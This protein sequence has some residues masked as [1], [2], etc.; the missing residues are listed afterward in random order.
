MAESMLDVRVLHRADAEAAVA[1]G[2]DRLTVV[3]LGEHR[4]QAPEPAVV[5][6]VARVS[7]LPVRV[8]L[9]LAADADSGDTTT[10]AGLVRMVGLAGDYV[11]A[12]ADGVVAGFLTDQ[13]EVD[14]E[15]GTALGEQLPCPWTFSRAIDRTLDHARSWRRVLGLPGVDSVLSAGSAVDAEH[16]HQQLIELAR[17]RTVAARLIAAGEVRPEHVPWLLRA[18]VRRVHIAGA[19][20][21]GGSWTKAHVDAGLVRS[22]RLLLDD[23]LAARRPRG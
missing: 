4:A 12:G 10:G 6:E 2:A 18:G 7:E 16:G 23:E 22:W 9:R 21:P 15:L 19:A 8:L 3:A 5:A 20:R 14:V 13:L 1:G 17:D 11:A